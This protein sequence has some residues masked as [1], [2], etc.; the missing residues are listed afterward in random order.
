MDVACARSL[1]DDTY[2]RAYGARGA[3]VFGD[4]LSNAGPGRAT[5]G[6]RRAGAEPLFLEAYLDEP[7]EALVSARLRRSIQRDAIIEIGNLAASNAWSMIALWG[8]AANDLGDTN[9]I[10]VATLTAPLRRM[11]GRIGVPIHELVRADPA[12]LGP[13][14]ADWGSYYAQDPWVCAGRIAEGQRAIAQFLARRGR[15]TAA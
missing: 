13:A 12:K 1:V 3:A 2:R 4:Y 5:L 6:Y 14:A 7:I 9:D 10:V 11:F 8:E 15:E